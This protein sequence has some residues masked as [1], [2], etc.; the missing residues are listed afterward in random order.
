MISRVE[1]FNRMAGN[2]ER[3][4]LGRRVGR[5]YIAHASALFHQFA[6]YCYYR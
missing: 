4:E 3:A 1:S 6:I 2:L 5:I